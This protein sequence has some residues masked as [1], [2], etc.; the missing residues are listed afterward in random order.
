MGKG[1][2]VL[3]G[4]N[5]GF[6]SYWTLIPQPPLNYP[7]LPGDPEGQDEPEISHPRPRALGHH[8]WGS[9]SLY[10]PLPQQEDHCLISHGRGPESACFCIQCI[11]MNWT[12]LLCCLSQGLCLLPYGTYSLVLNLTALL[13]S[14][15]PSCPFSHFIIT[16]SPASTLQKDVSP[17][18]RWSSGQQGSL[19]KG[20]RSFPFFVQ[21]LHSSGF[22]AYPTEKHSCLSVFNKLF[23]LE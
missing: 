7:C 19:F 5:L 9:V 1:G 6:Y 14:W 21:M 8:F 12:H 11:G 18:H 17:L 10:L 23:I 16:I 13:G 4:Q 20:N 2:P 15:P 3:W 22:P